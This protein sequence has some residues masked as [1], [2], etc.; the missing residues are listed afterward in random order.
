MPRD[1]HPPAMMFYFNDFIS[2]GA[3]DAMTTEEVG[4]YMRLFCKAWHETP[5][6]TVPDDDAVLSRWARMPDERWR[7]CRG[8][9]LRAFYLGNDGRYHQR[10][11]ESEYKKLLV[12]RRKRSQA[13][14]LAADTRWM[15]NACDTHSKGNADAMRLHAISASASSAISVSKTSA[16][17]GRKAGAFTSLTEA[18]LA[19]PAKMLA[20]F[21]AQ[22]KKRK[23]VIGSSEADRFLVVAV[24]IMAAR[25]DTPVG[26]F[27]DTIARK[28]WD[29]ITQADEDEAKKI[30]ASLAPKKSASEFSEAL[31]NNLAL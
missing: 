25:G 23:P 19:D 17:R 2:D 5:V 20:W 28:K 9:V 13:A 1:K 21:E 14:K 24:G 22:S 18:D 15:P 6:G 27:A 30:I 29:R 12:S 4:A 7:A 16:V 3:V 31:A 26:L 11:M 8:A 10:R